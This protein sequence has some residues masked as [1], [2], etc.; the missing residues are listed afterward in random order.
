MK[1]ITVILILVVLSL[2]M[3]VSNLKTKVDRLEKEVRKKRQQ[4]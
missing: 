4:V 1:I 3:D 2:S